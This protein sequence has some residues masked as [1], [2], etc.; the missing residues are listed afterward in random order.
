MYCMEYSIFH[1]RETGINNLSS[2]F[3]KHT[4]GLIEHELTIQAS[5]QNNL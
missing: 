3:M 1:N 5:Y 2:F 4:N